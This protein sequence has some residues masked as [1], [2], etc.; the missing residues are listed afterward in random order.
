M[1][2]G[3]RL[4]GRCNYM[5]FRDGTFLTNSRLSF[6]CELVSRGIEFN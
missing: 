1:S 4:I 6:F 2:I 3:Y 5:P